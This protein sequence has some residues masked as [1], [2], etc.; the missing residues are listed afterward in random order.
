MSENL[1]GFREEMDAVNAIELRA[2]LLQCISEFHQFSVPLAADAITPSRR[3]QVAEIAGLCAASY[4]AD[5][6]GMLASW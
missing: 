5:L 1:P 4:L 3:A 6:G 2:Q